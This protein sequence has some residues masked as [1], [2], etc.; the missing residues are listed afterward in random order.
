MLA[1]RA[2]FEEPVAPEAQP[3]LLH[4]HAKQLAVYFNHARAQALRAQVGRQLGNTSVERSSYGPFMD[5]LLRTAGGSKAC[6]DCGGHGWVASKKY[7]RAR[8]EGMTDRQR[9][10]LHLIE[11]FETRVALPAFDR[12]CLKCNGRGVIERDTKHRVGGKVTARCTGSSVSPFRLHTN[13]VEG[14][15]LYSVSWAHRK[16]EALAMA[17]P[18][19]VHVLETFFCDSSDWCKCLESR[20]LTALWHA[21]P[22]GKMLLRGNGTNLRRDE[23]W[24]NL[25]HEQVQK[26]SVKLERQFAACQE[27]AG[28]VWDKAVLSWSTLQC[29]RPRRGE[30]E[31]RRKDGNVES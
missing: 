11:V 4:D 5:Q 31:Q 24:Q 9:D 8:K 30:K 29:F 19:A 13:P 26:R 23:Y 21:T 10:L 3:V 16:V 1:A 7:A 25:K 17:D 22:A 15:W 14:E 28:E 20:D 6:P 2:T 18:W 12:M 27:Q